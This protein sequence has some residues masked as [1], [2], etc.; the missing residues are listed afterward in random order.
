MCVWCVCVCVCVCELFN[1]K[2]LFQQILGEFPVI[3]ADP[4]WNIHMEVRSLSPLFVFVL[5]LL[6]LLFDS[7]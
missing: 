5:F 3:M 6:R 7:V 1:F 4:P 2:L